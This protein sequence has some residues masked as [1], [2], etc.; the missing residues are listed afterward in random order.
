MTTLRSFQNEIHDIQRQAI[1]KD[2]IMATPISPT[3]ATGADTG[4]PAAEGDSGEAIHTIEQNIIVS[5]LVHLFIY[6]FNRTCSSHDAHHC[7]HHDR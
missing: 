3:M 4:A 6:L 5:V 1:T 2:T 7:L